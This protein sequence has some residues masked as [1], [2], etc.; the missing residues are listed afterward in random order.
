MYE[1]IVEDLELRIYDIT[2]D[3]EKDIYDLL[4][5]HYIN[6]CNTKGFIQNLKPIS[7]KN[8]IIK[9]LKNNNVCSTV[10]VKCKLDIIKPVY[11][12]T[13][14]VTVKEINKSCIIAINKPIKCIIIGL[15]PNLFTLDD[16]ILVKVIE[17]QIIK[18]DNVI[19][20]TSKYIKHI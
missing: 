13:L 16:K 5:K 17:T 8:D 10:F 1:Y 6:K 9:G 3:F 12:S 4:Y 19:R 18:E 11:N 14:V 7:Y 15:N 20:C 2:K